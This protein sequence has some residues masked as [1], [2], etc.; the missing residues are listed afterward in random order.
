VSFGGMFLQVFSFKYFTMPKVKKQEKL[1][2][3]IE[4]TS[5]LALDE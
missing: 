5:N 3:K 4:G 1:K 2:K